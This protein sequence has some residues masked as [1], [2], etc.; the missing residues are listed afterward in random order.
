MTDVTNTVAKDSHLRSLDGIRAICITLVILGHVGGTQGLRDLN[1]GVGDYAHLGV[2][3]F[4]VISG[5]LITTL[6][7]SEHEKKGT[8][9]LKLFYAR[10]S[11]RIFPASYCYLACVSILWL[12]GIFHWAASDFWHALTYTVNYVPQP[13][14][15]I[16]HLWSL[17]VEEQ[18]YLLWPFAFVA[19]GPRRAIWVAAAV[20]L[21]GPASRSLAWLFLRH[22]PYRDLPMFPVVADSLAMGCLLARVRPWLEEQSWYLQLFKPVFSL[23]LLALIFVINRYLGYTVV[24]VA[25]MSL[26]NLFVAILI[27]RSVYTSDDW[28]GR[29]LNWKP[30]AFVG[31]LSYSLY[32]WQQPFLNRHANGW[33]NSFPQNL[34][35]AVVAALGSYLL[36]EKP[37]LKLRHR[38]RA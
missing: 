20:L 35:F 28:M 14:W 18:F 26:I 2:V 15:Q 6:L 37:L 5:F 3:V 21:L 11:L 16:G 30:I 7:L 22:G 17:S 9:S 33:V 38:L 4:F 24:E 31:V 10:R 25:G 36:L 13:S 27:H 1:F 8:V 34:V 19:L 32:L 12:A 23:L 29:V